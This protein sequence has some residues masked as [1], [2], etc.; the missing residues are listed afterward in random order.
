MFAF[1]KTLLCATVLAFFS[2]ASQAVVIPWEILLHHKISSEGEPPGP[3]LVYG[4]FDFDTSDNS[5]SNI[6]I[7]VFASPGIEFGNESI[8]THDADHSIQFSKT[9]PDEVRPV[10]YVFGSH[11]FSI[12]DV[13]VPLEKRTAFHYGSEGGLT[14]FEGIARP[15]PEP[16]TYAMMLA[17]L[18]LL[19]FVRMR[20]RRR[21][22]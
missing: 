22:S 12:I 15:I 2:S 3:T 16:Q 19:G 8:V 18:G 13:A 7:D 20:R 5:F 4:R 11:G 6:A 9:V 10:T 14:I 21:S 17:G 1:A